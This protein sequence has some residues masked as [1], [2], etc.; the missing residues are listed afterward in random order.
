MPLPSTATPRGSLNDA[1]VP[2]PLAE[3][4]FNVTANFVIKTFVLFF[5]FRFL[6]DSAFEK[7]LIKENIDL[8]LIL[9]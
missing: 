1:A 3:L 4:Y 5:M 6:Y 9:T 2:V 8:D 7:K